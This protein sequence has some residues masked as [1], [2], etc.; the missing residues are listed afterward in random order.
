M[1]LKPVLY[2]LTLL[3][4]TFVLSAC[5]PSEQEQAQQ[6][7]RE[8]Q[9]QMQL[10]ETTPEFEGQMA[11]ILEQYFDLKDALVASDSDDAA[12]YARTL[13]TSA[14]EVTREGLNEETLALWAS[15]SE[16][17]VNNSRELAAQNDVDDQRY[18]FEFVSEAMIDMVDTFRPVGY[19]VYHQSCPMVRDDS[20]DWLSREEQIRNPYHGD[21]MMNCGETI[22]RI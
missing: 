12:G 6:R 5:G 1:T 18:H 4:A 17:I 2:T 20:A 3:S 9:M 7:E 14:E 13:Q 15:F 11:D 22:R 16:V 10:V 19:E 21:R 8:M